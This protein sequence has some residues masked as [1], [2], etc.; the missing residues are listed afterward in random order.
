[1]STA[2]PANPRQPHTPA[3]PVV[4]VHGGAWNIPDETWPAHIAGVTKAAETAYALLKK[5]APA[6]EAV[7]AAIMVLEDD[8]T[9]DAGYGSFLTRGGKV[10]LDSGIMRGSDLCVGGVLMVERCKNPIRVARKLM[11]EGKHI[12]LIGEGAHQ[13]AEVQGIPLIDNSALITFDQDKLWRKFLTM[14]PEELIASFVGQ[15]SDPATA[16]LPG[17]TV[18]AIALDVNGQIAAGNSTGGT[19][20]KPDGR[21]GDS[22]IPGCGLMADNELGGACCTGWGEHI[23]RANVAFR[24][25]QALG[26]GETPV[27]AIQHALDFMAERVGGRAGVIALDAKGRIGAFHNAGRMAWAG[28]DAEGT[29]LRPTV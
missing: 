15:D 26:H 1:M 21:V 27:G 25:V 17:D 28:F 14:T 20:F 16:T 6:I 18:G 13:F 9:F 10:Q 3:T 11:E 2:Q 22:A 5:G 7:E 4:I 12:L 8:P 24:T 19:P 29:L 23:A